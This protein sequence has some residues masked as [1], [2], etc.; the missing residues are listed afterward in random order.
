[1]A[2][3]QLHESKDR[4]QEHPELIHLQELIVTLVSYIQ[5]F[6]FKSNWVPKFQQSTKTCTFPSRL[7]Q[8]DMSVQPDSELVSCTAPRNSLKKRTKKK[9][10]QLLSV[11]LPHWARFLGRAYRTGRRWPWRVC[12]GGAESDP[13]CFL[14]IC[15]LLWG[16]LFNTCSQVTTG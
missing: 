2:L 6:L 4:P 8:L 9:Q 12:F 7:L 1:M 11:T 14:S 10:Q 5:T 16:A 13:L 15:S 3:I